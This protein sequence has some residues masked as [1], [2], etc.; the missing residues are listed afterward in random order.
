MAEYRTEH[1][2]SPLMRISFAHN[3]TK[4]RKDDKHPDRKRY[5][6]TLIL[7]VSDV[8]GLKMLQ[9]MV[10]EVVTGQWGEKGVDRF[11][12][13][14][15]KNP[16]LKG[17]SKAARSKKSGEIHEGLGPDVVFIRAISNEPVSCF[18]KKRLPISNDKVLSGYWGKAVLNC[19]SWH[20][21]E[22]GD[23]ISFGISMFQ[24]IREDETLGVAS[25]NPDDYFEALSDDEDGEK[26][27]GSSG[28]SASDL[29]S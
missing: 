23:G 25:R 29:F 17:D 2:T 28:G 5:G 15:I 13:D 14:L 12:Q 8:A 10:A 11:K 9:G 6:A 22:N 16:I 24:M 19:F 20:T 18:D 7:P 3:L 27:S 26:S 1:K 21:D 4:P